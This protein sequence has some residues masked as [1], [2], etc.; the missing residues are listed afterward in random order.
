MFL[1]HRTIQKQDL[2]NAISVAR[3]VIAYM[4]DQNEQVVDEFFKPYEW[5]DVLFKDS[6]DRFP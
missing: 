5:D 6:V 1:F 4:N 3:N 2:A